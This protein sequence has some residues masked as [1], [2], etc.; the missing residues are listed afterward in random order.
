MNI[1]FN[2]L[3]FVAMFIISIHSIKTTLL[4]EM[5]NNNTHNMNREKLLQLFAFRVKIELISSELHRNN[6]SIQYLICDI[7]K[8]V[9]EYAIITMTIDSIQEESAVYHRDENKCN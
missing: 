3:S 6:S 1:T 2:Y 8:H 9:D 4:D 7:V 5:Q